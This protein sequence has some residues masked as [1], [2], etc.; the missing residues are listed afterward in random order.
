M[1]SRAAYLICRSPCSC[2]FFLD[3]KPLSA[4]HFSPRRRWQSS[5]AADEEH[6]A[7]WAFEL[8]NSCSETERKH[9]HAA[10]ESLSTTKDP[11]KES[12]PVSHSQL[13]LGSRNLSFVTFSLFG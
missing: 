5:K 6:S 2:Y 1:R 13:R 8:V 3:L 9:L 7:S 11:A 12:T 4:F 10:L